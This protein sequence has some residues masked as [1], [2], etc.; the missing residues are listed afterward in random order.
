MMELL[1]THWA[2]EPEALEKFIRQVLARLPALQLALEQGEDLGAE[3]AFTPAAGRSID[4]AREAGLPV[5]LIDNVAIVRLSGPM[6]KR[7]SR[8]ARFFGLTDMISVRRAIEAAVLDPAATELIL[9]V[10]SPGGTVAGISDLVDGVREAKQHLPITTVVDGMAA[11]AAYWVAS[12]TDR[13]VLGRMDMVGS[14][15]VVFGL[16]DFSKAFEEAGIEALLFSTGHYKGAGMVG[17]QI[18]EEQ[19]AEFQRMAD[20]LFGYFLADVERGR[21]NRTPNLREL[22]DG[23]VFIGEEAVRLGLADSVATFQETLDRLRTARSDDR[24]RR[25]R[26][27]VALMG[28]SD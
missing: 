7:A 6:V 27:D 15:G 14:I 4:G 1:R 19:R 23:R 28:F 5:Q 13:I 20:Q 24:P 25:A 10:D 2:M 11:S 9:S 8:F 16:Y 21:G 18:T 17:T 3:T 26:A 22:A 12:Q